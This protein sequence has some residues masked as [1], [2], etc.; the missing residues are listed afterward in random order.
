VFYFTIFGSIV[1]L[2]AYIWLL[3][4]VQAARVVTYTYVNPVIAV[5]LGWLVLSE[6][7]TSQMLAAAVTIILAVILITVQR[8]NKAQVRKRIYGHKRFPTLSPQLAGA[9]PKP[10]ALALQYPNLEKAGSPGT[11][12]RTSRTSPLAGFGYGD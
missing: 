9:A 12:E 10:D 3:K 2:P 11:S 1:A 5:F 6:P 7:I 8:L 4:T